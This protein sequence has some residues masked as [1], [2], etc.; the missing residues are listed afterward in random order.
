MKPSVW[1]STLEQFRDQVA[2]RQPVPASGCVSA[3]IA[4]LALNLLIK[5][6]EITQHKKGF[7]GEAEK[8]RALM[9]D[10]KT[11]SAQL[12]EYADEDVA[13][14]NAYLD[15]ARLPKSNDE[16]RAQRKQ[17]VA[18]AL[19]Q[20]IQTPFQAANSA[21]SGMGLCFRA[22]GLVP[23]SLIADLGSAAALLAGAARAFIMSAE[24]NIRQ[25]A[26]D[27]SGYRK[28]SAQLQDLEREVSE[29]ENSMR[30]QTASLLAKGRI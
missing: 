3:V 9:N 5:V 23:Q 20:A 21:A 22:A 6:L 19:Q 26:E 14:F 12:A 1:Q 25:L 2:S 28:V 24:F 11:L 13:A 30:K 10:A 8:L 17:A 7:E 18:V 4:N 15:S 16:E 27:S 29:K